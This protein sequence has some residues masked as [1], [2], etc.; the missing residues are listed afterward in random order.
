M[1]EFTTIYQKAG[2]PKG[3]FV[4]FF[5]PPLKKVTLTEAELDELIRQALPDN[6]VRDVAAELARETGVAKRQIYARALE[7]AKK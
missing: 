1:S 3:E 7:L 4:I 5:T 2:P 6:S